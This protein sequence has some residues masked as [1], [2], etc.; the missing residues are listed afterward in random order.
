M[1]HPGKV[2]KIFKGDGK[3]VISSDSSVQALVVMWDDNLMTLGCE[4]GISERLKEGDI[5]LIDYAP[6]L[7]YSPPV[8]RQ[9][10]C[11]ILRGEAAKK[12]WKEYEERH[13]KKKEETEPPEIQ[14]H[15]V[16]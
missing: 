13:K 7:N 5:V 4:A 10:I 9:T 14:S 2:L 16:R 11:K 12:T 6:I 3:E 8:P 15:N 1:F